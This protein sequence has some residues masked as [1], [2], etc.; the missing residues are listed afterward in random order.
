MPAIMAAT[1]SSP[2]TAVPAASTASDL[3][4][5]AER[6]QDERS[7]AETL[8]ALKRSTE[9]RHSPT[10]ANSSREER[11]GSGYPP[12]P[13]RSSKAS[14]VQEY[15]SLDDTVSY[16]NQGDHPNRFHDESGPSSTSAHSPSAATSTGQVC[17]NCGT[18]RTPLWR[19]SPE[20]KTICNACGLYYKA[21]NQMR[22]TN[23]KRN[24]QPTANTGSSSEPG[25]QISNSTSTPQATFVPVETSLP[26]TCPGGGRCNGTGGHAGCSGCPAFNNRIAKTQQL[27][28]TSSAETQLTQNGKS[29]SGHMNGNLPAS[30]TSVVVPACQNCGTT[31]TPLWRRDDNGHTICNAC[32]LYYKLHGRH[33]PSGMKKEHIKRRKRVMPATSGHTPPHAT[34]DSS[35]SPDPQAAPINNTMAR[36]EFTPNQQLNLPHHDRPAN[37]G[38]Q[39]DAQRLMEP[40]TQSTLSETADRQVSTFGERSN[41]ESIDPNLSSYA[42]RAESHVDAMSSGN[43]ETREER[44]ERIRRERDRLAEQVAAMNRQL[45]EMEE[46]SH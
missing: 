20:G 35:V 41:A 16:S 36:D 8:L 42:R 38:I 12:S 24:L 27:A 4:T 31:V 32:G 3:R 11:Q 17:S 13:S 39:H 33:R 5:Q 10:Y 28:S 43:Q 19:R 25:S 30:G 15:H 23:L 9:R 37:G 18:T 22:P 14:E 26:G 21:R 44:M 6:T 2:S 1:Y 29:A 46:E 34:N 40:P 45:Q 7:D